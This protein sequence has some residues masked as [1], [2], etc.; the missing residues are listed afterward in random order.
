MRRLNHRPPR[1]AVVLALAALLLPALAAAAE[2]VLHR[3]GTDD[4]ATL[5]PHK[6]AFPGEQLVVFDLFEGL[7]TLDPRGRPIPG[8]AHSWTVS[9][10]GKVYTF[11]LRPGLQ[12]SDGTPMSAADFVY[13]LQR[14]LDPATA[15]PYASRL[16]AIRNA[17]AINRGDAP[18][19]TLGVHAVD[20]ATVRIEL[21][22]PA[23]YLP[24][25]LATSAMP[26][27]RHRV[28]ALGMG[29]IRPGS[30]VGNGPFVIEQW[31][32]N[33]FVRLVRNP[34]Y[35][36]ADRVRLDAVVHYPVSQP[37][38]AVR[39]FRAGELDLILVAPPEQSDTLREQFGTGFKL[40]PASSTEVLAF[41][42]QGG[43]T[44]D[45]RVRRALSM[46]ID[47][48]AIAAGIVGLAGVE[49]YGYVPPVVSNYPQGAQ[50]DFAAWPQ[51][52]R[53]EEARR[54]LAEAGHLPGQ[55]L[56]IRLSF[57][58]SD[59]NR[60]IA[61]AIAVMWR[62]VGVLTDLD[63]RETKALVA[64]VSL[65]RFEAVRSVWNAGY[66]DPVAFLERMYGAADAGSMN[67]SGY[68]SER[69]DR[70]LV[71]AQQTADTR[72]RAALL[73]EA[74]ALALADHPVAPLYYLVGRRL[75]A[76]RVSGFELN[77]RGLHLSRWLGVEP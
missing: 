2:R 12:W 55:P 29:W 69:F 26:A 19:S 39:R 71:E 27:P 59:L 1:A 68:R 13:S 17:R 77:P 54:L 37:A 31:V 48:E 64:E 36:A 34:R 49:A 67:Q 32:P 24:D 50:A 18:V 58:S 44:A 8:A 6:V 45:L 53:T 42:V 74:E 7:T 47:R 63:Q 15:Y 30:F 41:N 40:I 21:E 3:T 33:G 62:S 9:G 75:V 61:T 14:A 43:P 4:P 56:R 28:E 25:A 20:R 38:S 11:R 52:K 70:L 72:K 73:R 46:A 51:A 66:Y 35:H 60:K 10:D 22:H 76:A 23:A 57:P 65:G 5:D 16:F